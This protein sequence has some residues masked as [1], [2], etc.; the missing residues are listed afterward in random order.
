MSAALPILDPPMR[1]PYSAGDTYILMGNVYCAITSALLSSI[2]DV[3]VGPLRPVRQPH[4]SSHST[5]LTLPVSLHSHLHCLYSLGSLAV[6]LGEWEWY[7]RHVCTLSFFAPACS[8]NKIGVLCARDSL[9]ALDRA[10]LP[11]TRFAP[12]IFTE[13]RSLHL[14][15]P[16]APPPS[17]SA[18]TARL[19]RRRYTGPC[20]LRRVRGAYNDRSSAP[21][22]SSSWPPSRKP[23]TRALEAFSRLTTYSSP[24]SPSG[25][26]GSGSATLDLKADNHNHVERLLRTLNISS[27]SSPETTPT[28]GSSPGPMSVGSG[29]SVRSGGSGRKTDPAPLTLDVSF[30]STSSSAADLSTISSSSSSSL[31]PNLGTSEGDSLPSLTS[32]TRCFSAP[33]SSYSR[34]PDSRLL[35]AV[36][37]LCVPHPA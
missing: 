3:F 10:E 14:S 5:A 4:R 23:P 13:Q 34:P 8:K 30:S 9:A 16:L 37:L 28:A 1:C 21:T 25:G 2:L 24:L 18:S 26:S 17:A 6:P 12:P 22:A 11:S 15:R 19:R 35:P 27:P 36:G 20:G 31:S 29:D 7:M 32:S 33:S